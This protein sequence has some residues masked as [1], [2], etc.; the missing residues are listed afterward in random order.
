M[1]K[2]G[3]RRLLLLSLVLLLA[4]CR[5]QEQSDA[6]EAKKGETVTEIPD[7]QSG[8]EVKARIRLSFDGK[9]AIVKLRDN[10]TSRDLLRRLP[11]ELKFSDYA[12]TEK[13]AR[14][15]KKLSTAGAPTGFDPA[16]GDVT[17][18]SPWGNLAIFYRDFGYA[19]GLISL[20]SIESGLE[21]LTALEGDATVT[22]ERPG[23]APERGRH[24]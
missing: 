12:D 6:L 10:P 11:L 22:L 15:P 1:D 23:F 9:A 14:L 24:E 18:Y 5:V 21:D 16:V 13:I 19:K 8:E 20:G 2:R 17:Y 4:A 7:H 3:M